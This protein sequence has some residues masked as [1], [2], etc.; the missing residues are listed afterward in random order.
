MS[1]HSIIKK[2]SSYLT[3]LFKEGLVEYATNLWSHEIIT[4]AVKENVLDTSK[5]GKEERASSLFTALYNA[6]KVAEP[7]KQTIHMI[8]LVGILEDVGGTQIGEVLREDLA[9]FDIHIPSKI[10]R[11][12]FASKHKKYHS[13]TTYVNEC[14]MG[15]VE[16]RELCKKVVRLLC[17]V[18]ESHH[19]RL[20]KALEGDLLLTEFTS[21]MFEKGLISK[22]I[23][24]GSFDEI[25]AD[26]QARWELVNLKKLE[27]QCLD[28][29]DILRDLGGSC[30]MA[31]DD[32]ESDWT[33]NVEEEIKETFLRRKRFQ[34]SHSTPQ[35]DSK[36]PVIYRFR[37][38]YSES[39]LPHLSIDNQQFDNESLHVR[40]ANDSIHGR[41]SL[42]SVPEETVSTDSKYTDNYCQHGEEEQDLVSNESPTFYYIICKT[43]EFE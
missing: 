31:A 30:K 12:V 10:K 23:K 33:K 5:G 19:H 37:N 39:D 27:K 13:E 2:W 35:N 43:H 21:K 38:A 41:K 22:P 6:V 24:S 3:F 29:L 9:E 18:L 7:T 36:K 8:R 34:K 42:E 17:M 26:F 4:D 40:D 20:L 25:M 16:E 11:S 32:L 1:L 15:M 28:F 14:Q